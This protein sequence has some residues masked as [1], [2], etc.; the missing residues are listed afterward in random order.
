MINDTRIK[1]QINEKYNS[2][3][4]EEK[5]YCQ[6]QQEHHI[7]DHQTIN[8]QIF[9]QQEDI[10][11]L[12]IGKN[13]YTNGDYSQS[14]THIQKIINKYKHY[15]VYNSFYI[16]LLFSYSNICEIFNKHYIYFDTLKDIMK[17]IDTLC[18]SDAQKNFCKSIYPTVCLRLKHY[19]LSFEYIHFLNDIKGPN[20]H[21]QN[22]SFFKNNDTQK[23]LLLYDGGGLGDK[24]MLSRFIPQLCTTYN[25]NTIV[26]LCADR[27]VWLFQEIYTNIPN[28]LLIPQSHTHLLPM[29][30]YHCSLLSLL[31]YLNITY[32]NI[33]QDTTISKINVTM[34]SQVQNIVSSFNKPTYVLNWKGTKQFT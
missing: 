1:K 29:F 6:V 33:Y 7:E 19:E 22:M 24:I 4:K 9:V 21:C 11:T 14:M 25:K 2:H 3:L 5:I 18:I 17:N 27:L 20:I 23:T 16:D 8:P 26:F 34:T 15:N 12:N 28:L 32:N 31:K 13:L 30:D 10:I